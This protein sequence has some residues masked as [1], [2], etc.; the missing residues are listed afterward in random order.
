MVPRLQIN[1][2]G[3][4]IG[5]TTV[6]WCD[7]VLCAAYKVYTTEEQQG[8]RQRTTGIGDGERILYTQERPAFLA[9]NR[10]ALPPEIVFSSSALLDGIKASFAAPTTTDKE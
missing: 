3:S 5:P 10:Y 1:G 4:G 8:M 6:E 9:K 7:A 2:R